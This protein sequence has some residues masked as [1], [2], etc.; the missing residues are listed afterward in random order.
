MMAEARVCQSCGK[1]F[2]P[3][4]PVRP[5]H[6]AHYCS[7]VCLHEAV[8][9][10]TFDMTNHK[11]RYRARKLG[12]YVPPI[13]RTPEFW[14]RVEKSEGCWIW[15]GPV[16]KQTGYGE[17]CVN[18]RRDGAH[19]HAW[20]LANGRPVP[21]GLQ[22]MHSCDNRRCVRPD[23]LSV[24]TIADNIAD[25]TSKGRQ[26]VG[27]RIGTARLTADDVLAIRAMRARGSNVRDI[28]AVFGVCSSN[29]QCIVTGQTW[30]H[31][32]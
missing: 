18:R 22:V 14:G 4:S 11:A 10:K 8:R 17:L 25:K 13:P 28:A 2:T 29:V 23:H 12:L 19:R 32:K 20:E 1:A 30:R 6:P 27:E 16:N 31:V 3:K 5:K 26:A 9:P 7:R 24:G 21:A 15:L